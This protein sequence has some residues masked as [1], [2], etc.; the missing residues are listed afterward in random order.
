MKNIFI[1]H[2]LIH[3][4]IID[5]LTYDLQF[6]KEKLATVSYKGKGSIQ[7][8]F[9]SAI[10][11]TV[12]TKFYFDYCKIIENFCQEF[13]PNNLAMSLV[14]KEIEYLKYGISD[15]FKKH[16][17]VISKVNK[18]RFSTITMLSKTDNIKGG[19]LLLYDNN[20]Y[21]YDVDLQIG[22]TVVFYSDTIHE[23]TPITCGGREVLVSW[24]YDRI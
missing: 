23:V 5:D 2:K 3:Q 12:N 19:D 14:V 16:S 21:K 8:E 10:V 7:K 15:H 1:K 4:N 22:E 9:R 18:R 13:S 11:K 24:V 6:E 17:D 20:L